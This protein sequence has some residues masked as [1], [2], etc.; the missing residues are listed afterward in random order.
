MDIVLIAQIIHQRRNILKVS[1][2]QL[3]ELSGV[4]IK[5]IY[6]IEQGKAN[7]SFKTLYKVLDTLGL[8]IKL[9]LKQINVNE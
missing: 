1:Q 5:T 9:Q 2:E 6:A 3:S 7:P 4:G 8:E